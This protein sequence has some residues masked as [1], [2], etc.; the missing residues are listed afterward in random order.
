M[1]DLT[2]R[3]WTGGSCLAI[4]A[5]DLVA[6]DLVALDLAMFALY[7]VSVDPHPRDHPPP[8]WPTG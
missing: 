8:Q 3:R 7:T 6:L 1:S 4:V 5:L 2:L